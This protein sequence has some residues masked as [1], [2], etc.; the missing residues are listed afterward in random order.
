MTCTE[1]RV[2]LGSPVCGACR[3]AGRVLGILRAGHLPP[4]EERRVTNLLRGSGPPAEGG[5]KGET[6]ARTPGAP[7]ETQVKVEPES[8]SEYSYTDEEGEEEGA[9]ADVEVKEG[10]GH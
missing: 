4:S 2:F 10:E 9:S 6:I 1:C 7:K 3:A 5:T 8:K